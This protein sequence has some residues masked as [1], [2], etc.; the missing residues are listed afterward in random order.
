MNR[1]HCPV[2]TATLLINEMTTHPTKH[3]HVQYRFDG[4]I[5]DMYDDGPGAGIM[6]P[7]AVQFIEFVRNHYT[8]SNHQSLR[9][10]E[11]ACGT[12]RFTRHL[13]SHFSNAHIVATDLSP[14]MVE[15]GQR[16]LPHENI[17]WH[18]ANMENI[19]FEDESF[20]IIFCQYGYMFCPD[21]LRAFAET[22]RVLRKGGSMYALVWDKLEH[23]P[24]LYPVYQHVR[25]QYPHVSTKFFETPCSMHDQEMIQQWLETHQFKNINFFSLPVT[26]GYE[27]KERTLLSMLE[28]SPLAQALLD[29]GVD[30]DVF[31][32]EASSI[33][34]HM[35]EEDGTV[36]FPLKAT[37]I[38]SV[39]AH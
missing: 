17:S 29:E 35:E 19:P 22:H 10:L 25:A 23:H 9:I 8:G 3:H 12:G 32:D 16:K 11:L 14:G 5:P 6:E 30:L 38:H 1:V 26:G 7:S 4:K 21:K 31:V 36:A 15:V 33:F 37:L 28:G 13:H 39:K 18:V 2:P 20:D 24:T 27:S 34:D